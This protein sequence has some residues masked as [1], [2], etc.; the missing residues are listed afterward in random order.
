MRRH[1]APLTGLLVLDL[2]WVWSG[3]AVS[4]A[5]A[6][7]GA[8]VVKIEH[9]SRPDN[10]RMRGRPTATAISTEA[11]P[12]ELSC[13]FQALNRGKLS[14]ALDLKSADGSGLG[15]GLAVRTVVG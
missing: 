1:D 2:S 7:V 3:P 12:L 4:V 14:V 13:Y 9:A 15:A 10:S 8:T 11:P 6:D 5:L